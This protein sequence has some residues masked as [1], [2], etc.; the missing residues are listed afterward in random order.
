LRFCFEPGRLKGLLAA[1][2]LVLQATAAGTGI[3]ATYLGASLCTSGLGRRHFPF[4]GLLAAERGEFCKERLAVGEEVFIARAKVVQ[5]CFTIW[6]ENEA[7]LGTP[8]ITQ[9]PDIAFPAIA[10]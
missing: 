7:I 5:P 10:G 6:R 2:L 4:G 3:V 8:A 1:A 9:E